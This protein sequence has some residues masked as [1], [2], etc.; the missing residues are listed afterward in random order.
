MKIIHNFLLLL[1]GTLLL[2]SCSEG[3]VFSGSP[4]DT[5]I[6]K[7]TLVGTLSTTETNVVAGQPFEVQVGI[8]QTFD[9]N[10][11]V[12]VT[13]FVPNTNKRFR[14][15]VIIPAGQTSVA[16]QMKAP[17]SDTPDLPY[18]LNM[19]AY[20]SAIT[21]DPLDTITG[22]KGKQYTLTSNMLDLDFGDAPLSSINHSICSVIL[23]WEGPHYQIATTPYNGLAFKVIKDGTLINTLPQN[24]NNVTTTVYGKSNSQ[25]RNSTINNMNILNVA[26]N[27]SSTDG[28][29]IMK[30]YAAKLI[31]SPMDVQCRFTIRFPDETA[32][33]LYCVIPG[34]VANNNINSGFEKLK[35]V[36]TTTPSG[37]PHYEA[38]I[39]P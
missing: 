4:A 10:V 29:Y 38:S 36:K 5:N 22:F 30:V 33:T 12:E 9:V 8:P 16:Y 1:F 39:I 18:H 15:T 11:N 31:T 7:V 19:K 27:G 6:P 34:M 37:D 17:G 20:L 35:V 28:V 3:D 13:S 32:K 14:G 26:G 25:Q 24:A 23:D 2:T 21:T